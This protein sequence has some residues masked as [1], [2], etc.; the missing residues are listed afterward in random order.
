MVHLRNSSILVFEIINIPGGEIRTNTINS[1]Y[2]IIWW[3]LGW[4]NENGITTIIDINTAKLKFNNDKHDIII[5]VK[6]NVTDLRIIQSG[7]GD[8]WLWW[9]DFFILWDRLWKADIKPAVAIVDMFV[10]IAKVNKYPATP[11]IFDIWE[12]SKWFFTTKKIMIPAKWDITNAATGIKISLGRLRYARGADSGALTELDG[13]TL[14]LLDI[15]SIASSLVVP[16]NSKAWKINPTANNM[17]G[18]KYDPM[19]IYRSGDG[20]R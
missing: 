14:S 16:H 5:A 8:N 4:N 19:E 1:K 9:S 10:V 15:N 13:W 6:A 12:S 3:A 18:G 11:K 7:D 20:K 2:L 17:A